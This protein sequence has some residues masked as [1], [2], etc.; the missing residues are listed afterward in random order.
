MNTNEH[1]LIIEKWILV[2]QRRIRDSLELNG[3]VKDKIKI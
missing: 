2:C 3:Y 1:E